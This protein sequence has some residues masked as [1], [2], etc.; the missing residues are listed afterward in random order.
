VL[1]THPKTQIRFPLQ[2]IQPTLRMSRLEKV[3]DGEKQCCFRATWNFEKM[4]PG[5]YVD[6]IYEHYSPA[7]FLR[8]ADG[9]TSVAIHL[10]VDT[11]EVTRWFLMPAGKE[12]KDWRVVRY[13]TGKPE[14]VEE[15]KVV[16]EYLA[17]DYTI[18]AYKLMLGKAGYTYEV[19]WHYK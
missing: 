10:Q 15:V 16:T 4:P 13:K 1:A 18:L 6:L 3:V 9:A 7:V 19:I 14:T 5:E 2:K 12:Y 11:A 8:R 17:E